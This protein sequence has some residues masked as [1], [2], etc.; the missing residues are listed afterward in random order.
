MRIILNFALSADGKISTRGNSPAHFTSKR[1]LERLH[2]IRKQADAIL[3]GRGTL[4]ADQ[5]SLTTPGA[6]PLRCVISRHGNFDPA[7]PL[8]HTPGGPRHLIITESQERPNLPAQIHHCSLQEW[9]QRVPINTLLCEGGGSLAHE[10][11]QHDLVD[12]INLTW[13]PHTLF[14]GKTAPTLTGRPG[15]FLKS[16]KH[17]ELS[18]MEELGN[19]EV[20]L[21]YLKSAHN[22]DT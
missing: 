1:D 20:F 21:T 9:L 2:E 18:K 15:D 10:L 5:M 19:G 11:F 16:S 8:F 6:D 3:V 22:K 17:Y 12:E 4:E 7:H 13:A 14:G